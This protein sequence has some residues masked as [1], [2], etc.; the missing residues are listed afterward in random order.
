MQQLT[1]YIAVSDARAAIDWYVE[2]LGADVT[3]EPI[4]M[5]DGQVGH[6]ELAVGEARWMMSDEY[7]DLHVQAPDPGRGAAVTLHLAVADVDAL[8][9][10][11]V[12]A[13]ATLDRGP[14]DAPPAG[15][16]A[17]LRD[18]FGHRWFLNAPLA[19]AERSAGDE[20]EVQLSQR[21]PGERLDPPRIADEK[22]M[23]VGYLEHVR[24]TFELKCQDLGAGQLGARSVDPSTLSLHGLIRHLAGVERWWLRIN[25]LGEDIPLIFYTDDNPDLDFEPPPGDDPFVDLRTWREEVEAS[26]RVIETHDLDDEGRMVSGAHDAFSLRWVIL[27]MIAEYAQHNGH[28]DLLRERLDGRTG[29]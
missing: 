2:A 18:P 1:P 6:V 4:V 8:T 15:R 17:V 22:A 28:A 26:R 16:V 5:P 11:A 7:P 24:R 12:S 9:E 3:F 10:R 13:G 14:E 20:G 25:F 29:A 21:W 19:P 27:R 23:L